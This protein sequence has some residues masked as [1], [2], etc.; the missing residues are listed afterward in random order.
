MTSKI[1]LSPNPEI[2]YQNIDFENFPPIMG[3]EI[4]LNPYTILYRSYNTNYPIISDYPSF[5]GKYDNAKLYS[6]KK[7][8][9]MGI[10][11]TTNHIKLLDIRYI[12]SLLETIIHNKEKYNFEILKVIKILSLSFGLTSLYTQLKLIKERYNI[13]LENNKNNII[14]KKYKK[15]INFFNKYE[16]IKNLL[17]KPIFI[18]PI[19]TEAYRFGETTND[20]EAIQILKGLFEDHFDGIISPNLFS[21]SEDDEYLPCEIIIFNPLKSGIQ[22]FSQNPNSITENIHI[23][24]LLNFGSELLPEIFSNGKII[25]G[26]GKKRMIENKNNLFDSIYQ[27]N[28]IKKKKKMISLYNIGKNIKQDMLISNK[29]ALL[30]NKSINQ[31]I[32]YNNKIFSPSPPGPPAPEVKVSPWRN[33]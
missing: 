4:T 27:N 16:N 29:I 9:K 19:E 18:N 7:N 8:Y 15:L 21:P 14:I 25:I 30:S 26:S 22:F 31:Q 33:Y 32:E 12:K 28:R 20:S 3:K 23:T 24:N 11:M 6:L 13:I 5:Y 2:I 17:Y 10:F 1:K